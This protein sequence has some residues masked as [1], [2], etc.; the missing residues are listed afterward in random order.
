VGEMVLPKIGHHGAIGRGSSTTL[1]FPRR[2]HS[3]GV[4][5]QYCGQLGKT[6]TVRSPCRIAR[7][8]SRQPAGGYQLYLPEEWSNDR[9]RLRKAGVPEDVGFK[10]KPEIALEQSAAR[11]R[12]FA[13]RRGAD[14]CGLR[15]Q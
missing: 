8:S 5:R 4:A 3:V 7:Q 13:A 12:R 9:K 1:V 2:R 6:E 15:Q 14:G 10:T 11:C